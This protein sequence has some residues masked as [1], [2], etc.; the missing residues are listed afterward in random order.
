MTIKLSSI[1]NNVE[2]ERDGAYIE[3]PEWTGVKLGVR[4]LE[5][6]AYKLAVDQLVQ[7]YARVYKGKTAPPEVRDADIGKLLARHILFDWEGFDEPYT[8]A[9]ALE[10]L[11][12]PQGNNLMKQISWAAGQ[13]GETEI[14]FVADAVKNSPKPSATS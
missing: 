8:E 10:I 6:P 9:Y 2:A 1:L 7:K 5:A 4:S 14:E 3:I 13:V 11:A 12:S